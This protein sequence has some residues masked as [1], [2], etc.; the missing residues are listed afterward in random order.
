MNALTDYDIAS[1]EAALEKAG[2]RRSHARRI[3]RAFFAA[4]GEPDWPAEVLGNA[5]CEWLRREL[6]PRVSRLLARTV[7][8]DGEIGRASCRERV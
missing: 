3:F 6:P 7:S 4:W 8:G 1:L 2:H 5:L